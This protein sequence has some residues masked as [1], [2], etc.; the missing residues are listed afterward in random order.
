M[1]P[2][3]NGKRHEAC[4]ESTEFVGF[5]FKRKLQSLKANSVL[6]SFLWEMGDKPDLRLGKFQLSSFSNQ[7]KRQS[8]SLLSNFK[9]N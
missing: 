9:T 5:K 2:G 8:K 4:V 6:N 1:T 7:M 3:G